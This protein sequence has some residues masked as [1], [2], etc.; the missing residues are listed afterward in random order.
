MSSV[1]RVLT[2]EQIWASV[3][4]I[5]REWVPT[6]EWGEPCVNGDENG[7]FVTVLDADAKERWEDEVLARNG[8]P[9]RANLGKLKSISASYGC[10]N[11]AGERVFTV[12]DVE[13]L[14]K[15]SGNVVARIFDVFC[16]LNVTKVD[17]EELV[18]N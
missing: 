1:K 3:G 5:K 10:V 18:K 17:I 12:E 9:N 8:Q 2:A 15:R 13:R 4:D 16:R 7:V 6:P 14:R 11:D